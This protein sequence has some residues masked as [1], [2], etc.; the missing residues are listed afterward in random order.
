MLEREGLELVDLELK[1]A[2]RRHLLRITIDKADR[3]AYR[4]SAVRTEDTPLTE[5]VSIDDCTRLS[6]ELSPLLDVE[7]IIPTAYT[8]EV[9]SPGVNRVLKT[10][11]HFRLAIGCDVRVKTRT[12]IAPTK[13][14]FFIAR[15]L[16]VSDESIFLETK[17]ATSRGA[18]QP[19]S[20]ESSQ[21]PRLEIPFRLIAQANIEYR[22]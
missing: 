9:T 18:A 6:R 20:P 13:D 15:L 12:P 21:S 14:T 1:R 10:P 4:G 8:L 16:E 5:E 2:P 3:L 7:D 19:V 11:R 17:A 22:F